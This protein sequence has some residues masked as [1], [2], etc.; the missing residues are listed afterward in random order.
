MHM[1]PLRE[2]E[3]EKDKETFQSGEVRIPKHLMMDSRHKD[4]MADRGEGEKVEEE[5]QN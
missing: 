5:D 3:G 4:S 2:E 1:T